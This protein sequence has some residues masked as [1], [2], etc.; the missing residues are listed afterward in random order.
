MIHSQRAAEETL[1]LHHPVLLEDGATIGRAAADL[2]L[3]TGG[4][5][6]ALGLPE[7]FKERGQIAGRIDD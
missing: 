1:V 3:V 4:S 7:N 5:G 6:V 2:P